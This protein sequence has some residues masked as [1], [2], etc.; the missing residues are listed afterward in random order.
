[1][2]HEDLTREDEVEGSSD[3][4][5]GIVFAVVFLIIAAWPLLHSGAIRWWSVGVAGAFAAVAVVMPSILA[6]PNRLWMKFGLLL[7][8][9]VS[10]VAL[11]ILFY[12]VFT[13]I[14]L[15]MRMAGKDPLRLKADPNAK[16]YWIDREPPGPPPQSMTNQF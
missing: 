8:K 6:V 9:I 14:G 12:L 15:V 7:A 1:M 2:S 3:R 16:S 5:F 4:S 13:P 11:G 10:P